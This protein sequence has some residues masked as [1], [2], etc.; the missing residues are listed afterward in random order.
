MRL[1][2]FMTAIRDDAGMTT[3]EYAVGTVATI[4]IGGLLIK[5]LSSSTMYD[6]LW[7]LIQHAFGSIFG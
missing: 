4:G 1:T 7:N 6:L 2:N 5:L 3:A